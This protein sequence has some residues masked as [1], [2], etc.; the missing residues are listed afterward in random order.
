[1]ATGYTLEQESAV[2]YAIERGAVVVAA[3]GNSG[4]SSKDGFE[5]LAN[6]P[7]AIVVTAFDYQLNGYA[8]NSRGAYVGVAA[9]GVRMPAVALTGQRGFGTGTSDATALT[10][11]AIALVWS[12]YPHL[13]NRQVVARLLATA[14]DLGAPGKDDEFG[15]GGI[16]PYQAITTEVPADAPNPIF[17]RLPAATP[18]PSTAPDATDPP[19]KKAASGGMSLSP[20][21]MR[22]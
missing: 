19:G 10:S 18:T 12:K 16:R 11:G 17:D 13:T 9:P 20:V 5:Y 15:Y 14:R 8:M 22:I 7:G 1:M 4:N 21:I 2:R 6:C 3:S